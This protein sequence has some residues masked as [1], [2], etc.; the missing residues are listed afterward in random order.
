MAESLVFQIHGDWLT[1]F[2]RNLYYAEEYSYEECKA[3]LV[4]SLCLKDLSEKEKTELF[5]SI[6]YGEKKLIGVNE[7]ELVDDTDFD[8][9]KY[10]R[11]T[12]PVFE[13]KVIGFLLRDGV[14]VQCNYMEHFTTLD[15]IGEELAK[16]ALIFGFNNRTKETYCYTDKEDDILTKQ[17]L[18]W[19]NKYT[20]F[21]SEYQLINI[22]SIKRRSER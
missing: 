1:D 20:D 5:E 17:Q 18:K 3:K 6:L 21:L 15:K 8:V 7:L 2:I 22:E 16:G 12:K 19:I 9:Y 13:N 10:S 11:F 4:N 14:F